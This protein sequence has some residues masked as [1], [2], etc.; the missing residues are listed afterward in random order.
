M[1]HNTRCVRAA[2]ED[3]ALAPL[4][5]GQ[6]DRLNNQQLEELVV[7]SSEEELAQTVS[8][9]LYEQIRGLHDSQH[10]ARVA[11][12]R[13][14]GTHKTCQIGGLL[15]LMVM[16]ALSRLEAVLEQQMSTV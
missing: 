5:D 1:T 16:A 7:A 11:V 12:R 13:H 6:L 10:P 2:L 9:S 8:G 14:F 15:S 4:V 3:A